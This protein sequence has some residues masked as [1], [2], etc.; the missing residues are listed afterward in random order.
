M[1]QK[2]LQMQLR[3]GLQGRRCKRNGSKRNWNLMLEIFLKSKMFSTIYD[4]VMDD[5]Y[6]FHI[7]ENLLKHFLLFHQLYP[8]AKCTS[9]VCSRIEFQETVNQAS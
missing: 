7:F 6:A 8:L 4:K 5:S 9:L 1:L 2:H 3:L